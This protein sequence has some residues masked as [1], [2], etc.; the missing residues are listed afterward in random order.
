MRFCEH[1]KLMGGTQLPDGGWCGGVGT[2]T[3]CL[4]T[5]GFIDSGTFGP[6]GEIHSETNDQTL[7]KACGGKVTEYLHPD[8]EW[9]SIGP[10]VM[11][12]QRKEAK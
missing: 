3:C 4:Q 5:F 12:L 8:Y 2:C 6:E 9:V 11:R 10:H 7:C 1:G